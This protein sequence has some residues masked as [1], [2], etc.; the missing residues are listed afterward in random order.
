M[1]MNIV[2]YGRE[3]G[4]HEEVSTPQTRIG[5]FERTAAAEEWL[6][7]NG[8]S[9]DG[10]FGI[11]GNLVFYRTNAERCTLCFDGVKTKLDEA[12]AEIEKPFS[13]KSVRVVS[14]A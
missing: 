11:R 9:L 1:V 6:A 13:P 8:F 14:S 4:T 7:R 5:P 12:F 2:V 10:S 3:V